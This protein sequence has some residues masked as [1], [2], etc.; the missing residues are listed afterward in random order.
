MAGSLHIR[1]IEAGLV[2]ARISIF[3]ADM[4]VEARH[5]VSQS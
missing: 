2:V 1:V 3:A 5:G 4:K